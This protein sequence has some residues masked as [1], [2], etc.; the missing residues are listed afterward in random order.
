MS[1]EPAASGSSQLTVTAAHMRTA[2]FRRGAGGTA[3]SGGSKTWSSRRPPAWR[4]RVPLALRDDEDGDE[5]EQPGATQPSA[6]AATTRPSRS[7][8]TSLKSSRLRS[9]PQVV[10]PVQ[11][12]PTCTGSFGVASP[13]NQELP[14]S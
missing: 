2:D 13:T 3:G 7:I 1:G 4:S 12:E 5:A 6:K 9:A 8:E 10:P 14:P 11:I